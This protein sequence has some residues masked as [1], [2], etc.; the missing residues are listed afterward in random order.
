[1]N[2]LIT[3]SSVDI[4]IIVGYIGAVIVLGVW[5]SRRH[6][7]FDDYF[8]AGRVLTAP[9][10]VCTLVSTY[11]GIDVLLGDSELAYEEGCLLYT[12]PSPR[13]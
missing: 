1:M 4:A 5:L 12:S 2:S 3:L 7:N 6:K 11:Y 13:D 10:L 9:I 8:L